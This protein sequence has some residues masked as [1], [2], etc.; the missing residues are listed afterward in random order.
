MT[1]TSRLSELMGPVSC[2]SFHDEDRSSSDSS[3]DEVQPFFRTS[4]VMSNFFNEVSQ[5]K[6]LLE[7]M[8]SSLNDLSTNLDHIE[9]SSSDTE[10]QE[11]M[12]KPPLNNT[13]TQIDGVRITVD[14]C[15]TMLKAM[16]LKTTELFH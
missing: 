11:N 14:T 15:S 8:S 5:V 6:S 9:S 3:D 13:Y 7:Q 16:D 1:V 4:S 12:L 10:N 2:P